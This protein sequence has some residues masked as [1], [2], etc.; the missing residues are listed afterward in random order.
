MDVFVGIIV[1]WVITSR[2]LQVFLHVFELGV[3]PLGLA[4]VHVVDLGDGT[5]V[6]ILLFSKSLEGL[7]HIQSLL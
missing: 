5:E 4:L 2:G 6:L 7:T 3:K 1:V